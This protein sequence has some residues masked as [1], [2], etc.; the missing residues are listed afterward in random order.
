[1]IVYL[2]AWAVS[3]VALTGLC[4]LA[5]W[6]IDDWRTRRQLDREWRRR[7][8]EDYRTQQAERRR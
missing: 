2:I 4:I 6:L 1:M 3:V 5:Y 8:H 7:W